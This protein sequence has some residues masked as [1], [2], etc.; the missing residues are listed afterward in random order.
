MSGFPRSYASSSLDRAKIEG[1]ARMAASQTRIPPT[2]SIGYGDYSHGREK[3]VVLVGQCWVLDRRTW[4]GRFSLQGGRKEREGHDDTYIVL[5]QSGNLQKV[6]ISTEVQLSGLEIDH[7]EIRG[8]C[9]PI[10]DA[11][12]QSFDF[13]PYFYDSRR[14]DKYG[15]WTDRFDPENNGVG[16]MRFFRQ[17]DGMVKLLEDVRNGTAS[18]PKVSPEHTEAASMERVQ[19]RAKARAADEAK[20]LK[21]NQDLI[22]YRRKCKVASV[23]LY[24]VAA[25][26]VMKW[27]DQVMKWGDWTG[28][29]VLAWL[30]AIAGMGFAGAVHGRR[31]PKGR[32]SSPIVAQ[33]LF[34][35][36]ATIIAF[37]DEFTDPKFANP[38]FELIFVAT[39][40][41]GVLVVFCGSI[42]TL[43]IAMILNN[44]CGYPPKS[45]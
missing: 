42:I 8:D 5:N 11:D 37:W 18:L 6:W 3:E 34:C 43:V 9:V 12:I 31:H 29:P 36:A 44:V 1:L 14:Q 17:G 25:V 38:G 2:P 35:S 24:I 4:N 16:T 10:S 22:Q 7:S 39:M 28:A 26:L 27:V 30:V 13:D 21:Q 45:R 32:F 19:A 40:L 15:A 20:V 23:V 33:L 41:I